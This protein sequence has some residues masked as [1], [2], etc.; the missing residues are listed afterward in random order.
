MIRNLALLIIILC[1]FN[2]C[3]KQQGQQ[4][5]SSNRNNVGNGF[6]GNVSLLAGVTQASGGNASDFYWYDSN[7]KEI[8]LDDLKGKIILINF[9]ATWCRPCKTE[10]PDIENLSKTY[11]SRGLVVIGISIDKGGNLL[12]DVSDFASHNG[13]TYQIVIDNGNV[14]DAYGNINAIPTS[15]LVDKNGKIVDKW[16][17]VRDKAFLE[18]IVK[19]YLD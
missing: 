16:I 6:K 15:F 19:K 11:S 5:S 4:S 17:G 18:S 12:T 2:S 10:L 1:L 14:T 9:W 7:G 3:A 13:L 8:S